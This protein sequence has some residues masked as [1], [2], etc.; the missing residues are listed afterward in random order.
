MRALGFIVRKADVRRLLSEIDKEDTN[1]IDFN[2]FLE[3][4]TPKM[5]ERDTKEEIAK[6]FALFDQDGIGKISFRD[7]KRVVTELGEVCS[8]EKCCALIYRIIDIR[9]EFSTGH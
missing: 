9:I 1:P 7:L 3:L 4:L 8:Y 5:S 6:V 2:D